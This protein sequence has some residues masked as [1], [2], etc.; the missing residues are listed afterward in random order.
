MV[1]SNLIGILEK[2]FNPTLV[3]QFKLKLCI[4]TFLICQEDEIDAKQVKKLDAR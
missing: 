3:I 1:V 2:L 4:V